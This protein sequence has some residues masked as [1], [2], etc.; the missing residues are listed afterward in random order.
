MP[1][2]SAADPLIFR[3]ALRSDVGLIRENNEDA[4]F[5]D[6]DLLI[7]ADGMGGHSSGEV[8]SAVA[9]HT[10]AAAAGDP[11]ESF[12]TAAHRTRQTLRA[13]SSADATLETMGTTVVALR[14]VGAQFYA[15]HIG[16]S[17]LYTLRSGELTQVTTDHTH[18]QHLVETGR[19]TR[20][21]IATHPYRA[22]LLKSLDD[23]SGGSEPDLVPLDL[24]PGDRVLLCSDGLS[25]YVPEQV[26]TNILNLPDREEAADALVSAALRGGTRDNI[27]VIVADVDSGAAG[28]ADFA[29]AASEALALSEAA[30]R[31]LRKVNPEFAG[32]IS[33][34]A[35]EDD[36]L[37]HT[38][39]LPETRTS[40]AGEGNHQPGVPIAGI[41]AACSVVIVAVAAWLLI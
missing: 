23:Q 27:T 3:S 26:I 9:V 15:C 14:V 29:G 37:T 40:G 21:E 30:A 41:L 8:A 4:A 25:D 38:T 34:E 16:D 19:I 5:T 10:F 35:G 18:V 24:R 20:E 22:M 7:L 36:A 33:G 32:P 6:G 2:Q 17:R 11:P 28:P 12:S 13:M 1:H 39:L 31:A